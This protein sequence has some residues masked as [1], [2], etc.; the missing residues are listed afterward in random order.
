MCLDAGG[1][2]FAFDAQVTKARNPRA[3]I[4]NEENNQSLTKEVGR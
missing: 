3:F 2:S 4:A 1:H